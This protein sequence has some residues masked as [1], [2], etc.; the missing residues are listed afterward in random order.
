MKVQDILLG[1][2]AFKNEGQLTVEQARQA[3][4]D[5]GEV[6]KGI[7][8]GSLKTGSPTYRPESEEV[9]ATLTYADGSTEEVITPNKTAL[10]ELVKEKALALRMAAAPAQISVKAETR[11]TQKITATPTIARPAA[12]Q[13]AE[14]KTVIDGPTEVV[15]ILTYVHGETKEVV[16]KDKEALV[17]LVNTEVKSLQDAGQ[18]SRVQVTYKLRAIGNQASFVTET[19]APAVTQPVQATNKSEEKIETKDFIATIKQEGGKWIGEL[20]YKN[21]AGTERFTATSKS[22]LSMVTLV[23]KGHASVK[24]RKVVREQKLGVDLDKSYTFDGLT[25]EEFDALPKVAQQKLVDNEAMKAS[26]SFVREHPDYYSTDDNW[27]TIKKFLDNKQLPYTYT[28]LEYA[29][30]NLTDDDMLQVREVST[31][32][33]EAPKPE[34]SAPVVAT[35]QVASAAVAPATSAPQLRKRGTTGLTPGFSSAGGSTELETPE[36]NVRPREL[37]AAELKALP[38]AE[39]KKLYK[40]SLNQDA[41]RRQNRQF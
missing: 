17:A 5:A 8:H 29:F 36:E 41:I 26:L 1:N 35:P 37:S 34:D 31:V 12:A 39:H 11:K 19:E 10:A 21:G 14:E 13:R 33:S 6:P 7:R 30:D 18:P 15:A 2:K 23:G 9:I 28:N 25:Q 40:A 22:A 16:V 4:I 20:V 3:M 38:L 24:V 32:V 27:E